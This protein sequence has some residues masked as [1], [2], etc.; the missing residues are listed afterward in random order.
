MIPDF[1]KTKPAPDDPFRDFVSTYAYDRTPLHD[2]PAEPVPQDS[3]D[4]HKEKIT[5]DAAY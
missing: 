5:I 3:P 4:W 1:T 2:T